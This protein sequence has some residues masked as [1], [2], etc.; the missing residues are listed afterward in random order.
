VL[1][2]FEVSSE[3]KQCSNESTLKSNSSQLLTLYHREII[4]NP[5]CYKKFIEVNCSTSISVKCSKHFLN[6]LRLNV[7]SIVTNT[8]F[9]F[10]EVQRA[11][12]IVINDLEEP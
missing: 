9:E 4:S 2:I 6:N 5:E 8:L 7:Q 1:Q 12:S 10:R 3:V 11:I